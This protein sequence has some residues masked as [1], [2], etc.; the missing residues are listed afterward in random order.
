MSKKV[1]YNLEQ[2]K[3]VNEYDLYWCV[4]FLAAGYVNRKNMQIWGYLKYN[5]NK[6][7]ACSRTLDKHTRTDNKYFWRNVGCHCE[8][9]H[10]TFAVCWRT[11]GRLFYAKSL[12][13]VMVQFPVINTPIRKHII[14][15]KFPC[16]CAQVRKHP[17]DFDKKY[18]C[19]WENKCG[20]LF[21]L[22]LYL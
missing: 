16:C 17:W 15:Y 12:L 18:T 3:S 2:W 11:A 8:Y 20:L 14:S 4:P 13:N 9:R 19:N 10:G 7:P 21:W 1:A 5:L 22:T 6:L